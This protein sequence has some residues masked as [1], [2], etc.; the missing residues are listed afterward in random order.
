MDLSNL[1]LIMSLAF[2]LGMLHALDADHIM[3]VSGLMVG[4]Q[5]LRRN[6]AFC[7]R[8]ALG[9]GLV[10]LLVG[11]ALFIFGKQ[12]PDSISQYAELLVGVILV[13]L[14]GVLL[15]NLYRLRAHLHFHHHD[16]IPLH[17][18][19]H[20]HKKSEVHA[21]RNHHQGHAALFIG[22]VHGLAGS[23]PLLVL[24]PVSAMQ[25]PLYG[26]IYLLLFSVGVL[27]AMLL[28]GGVFGYLQGFMLRQGERAIKF[29]RLV[30]GSA[31]IITGVLVIRSVT[32]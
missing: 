25:S 9:H 8:W 15:L 5:R 31:A 22:V 3:A 16:G 30:T 11:T 14:G 28:F 7:L 13:L 20:V 12:L 32:L 6:I 17:A 19:W 26:V 10:L 27:V 21:N 23:A 24:V 18:H 2:G 4:Q 29:L 1:I